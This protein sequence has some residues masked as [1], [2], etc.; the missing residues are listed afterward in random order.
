MRKLSIF[1]A[2]AGNEVTVMKQF[3]LTSSMGKRLIAK[4]MISHTAV[5]NALHNGTLVI[6]AG[7]TNG[8]IAEEILTAIGQKG[9]FTRKRFFRGI[10]LPPTYRT[11]DTGRLAGENE[12]PGDVVITG[13]KWQNGKTIND[14]AETLKE[15]DVILKGANAL[16]L[17]HQRVAVLVGSLQGGTAIVALSAIVGRRVRLIVPIGLEKRIPGDIDQMA[18]KVN[19]PG[20]Q[21]Y[22]LLPIPGEVFTEIEALKLL[23]G[24]EAEIIAAGGVCGA[25][26]GLWLTITGTAEAE[27]EAEKLLR[28]IASEPPFTI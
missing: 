6:V 2:W 16:D 25:E 4:A 17:V 7:T 27:L 28:S 8:Y 15:G 3:I 23:T 10:T 13:G 14:V 24:V 20:V 12:F 18:N 21:G 11:T 5:K 1:S 9:N 19:S 22:R 26:G